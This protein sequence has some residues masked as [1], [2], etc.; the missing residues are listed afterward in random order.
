MDYIN[1][2][3]CCWSSAWFLPKEIQA[4]DLL[5]VE[6]QD[7]YICSPGS[8]PAVSS[9]SSCYPKLKVIAPLLEISPPNSPSG[10]HLCSPLRVLI[11]FPQCYLASRCHFV[12][13]YPSLIGSLFTR[14][15]FKYITID[16]LFSAR[17]LMDT[18]Y[19]TYF[20]F[21]LKAFP[22]F[23]FIYFPFNPLTAGKS[24]VTVEISGKI[25]PT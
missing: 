1:G 5:K 2:I 21:Y 9:L 12:T 22:D 17:I 16:H 3:S 20:F 4:G 6:K 25:L 10:F 24:H 19:D 18:S 23:L 15:Y 11:Q 8:L 7:Q 14:L 13:L